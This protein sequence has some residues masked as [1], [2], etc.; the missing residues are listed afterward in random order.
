MKEVLNCTS[1]ACCKTPEHTGQTDPTYVILYQ[2]WERVG[3]REGRE[4]KK[5]GCVCV[6]GVGEGVHAM[7]LNQKGSCQEQP[8]TPLWTLMP[9]GLSSIYE[10]LNN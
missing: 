8:L 4:W 3:E 10:V 9:T 1:E 6:G 2:T 5:E 7:F